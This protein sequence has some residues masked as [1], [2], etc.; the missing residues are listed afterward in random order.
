MTIEMKIGD[1]T[2]FSC[3][4]VAVWNFCPNTEGKYKWSVNPG[5]LV[6][7]LCVRGTVSLDDMKGWS[8]ADRR[9][10]QDRKPVQ[11]MIEDRTKKT[12]STDSNKKK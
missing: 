9:M 8:M 4:L 5:V 2:E 7:K 10:I 11:E 1:S 3:F 12:S 6:E